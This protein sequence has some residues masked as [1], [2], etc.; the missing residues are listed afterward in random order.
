[1]LEHAAAAPKT[2]A[3]HF[4]D[5]L[6]FEA[7][8]ADVHADLIAGITGFTV[9]DTRAATHYEQGHVPGAINLPHRRI[10]A[11][12]LA[13]HGVPRSDLLVTYCAGPHCNASTRGALRLSELG[14]EVKEMPG[15]MLGWVAEG[16]PVATG[17]D[18]SGSRNPV[19]SGG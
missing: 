4:R 1:M 7:D 3:V 12:A 17:P 11:A 18:A 9:I 13:E 14:R 10:T 19:A 8:C 16:F 5:R 15:G 2:A 6:S